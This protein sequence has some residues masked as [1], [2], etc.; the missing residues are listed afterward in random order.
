MGGGGGDCFL[1]WCKVLSLDNKIH[2]C[3]TR[4]LETEL[5]E[6]VSDVDLV[7]GEEVVWIYRRTPYTVK[8]LKV[9]VS[10]VFIQVVRFHTNL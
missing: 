9:M 10:D 6:S 2:I 5:C 7:V 1:E 8:I 4:N 3:H